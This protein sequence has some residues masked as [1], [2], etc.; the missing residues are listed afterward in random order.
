[1]T[2][3]A[4]DRLNTGY[5]NVNLVSV[6][7]PGG[8]SGTGAVRKNLFGL[9]SAPGLVPDLVTVA[10]EAAGSAAAAL[11][12]QTAAAASA[13]SAVNAPGT[14]GTSTT[15]NAAGT[16]AK[17]WTTQTGK[18]WVVGQWVTVA[19]TADPAG[20]WMLGQITAYNSGTGSLTVNVLY[21]SA[22][23]THTDWTISLAAP[24]PNAT[25]DNFSITKQLLLTGSAFVAAATGTLNDY[26]PAG[27]S[28]AS[29][30][31]LNTTGNTT[32]TGIAGGVTGRILKV[33]NTGSFDLVL[34]ANNVLSLAANRIVGLAS[35][36]GIRLRTGFAAELIYDGGSAVWRILSAAPA[37]ATPG[38][39]WAGSD[40]GAA[41]TTGD[42]KDAAAFQT[43][44]DAATVAW[45][46]NAQG[47]NAT[48][49]LGGNRTIGA[50]T[51]LK[52]GWTYS[53]ELVQDAT[54]SR[55][56]TWDAIWDWG[57][58]GTPILQT[59]ANKRDLVFAV[60]RAASGKL[61]ASFRK[62]A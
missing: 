27:L 19:R 22:S 23:T 40:Y 55:V 24:P 21:A 4:F 48:V 62:G 5:Y 32:I 49:T 26:S 59:A 15:S 42:L 56:P 47:Y 1:M 51:N 11:T 33:L 58:A 28:T 31:I 2:S 36:G 45:D 52:D 50:P 38:Q 54:G 17:T 25:I 39:I 14:S 7:N 20:V 10:G 9:S 35:N 57:Q 3:A 16:G 43:L 61:H 30:L 41:P 12:S 8:L 29:W 46:T 18:A 34:S 60:Y 53:L 44:T 37:A 6:G 13:L